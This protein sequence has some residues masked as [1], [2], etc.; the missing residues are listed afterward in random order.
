MVCCVAKT[1]S[2]NGLEEMNSVC[3]TH[4]GGLTVTSLIN[5][6]MRH[7]REGWNMMVVEG[8]WVPRNLDKRFG[9]WARSEKDVLF[10]VGMTHDRDGNPTNIISNFAEC[11][12][13]GILLTKRFFGEVGNFSDNPL[14]ISKKFWGLE[15]EDKGGVFK[16]ILGIKIC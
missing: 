12:L 14:E 3:R 2:K 13:N 6:G 9:M 8:S 7:A 4:R 15:A 10:P 5:K 1:I 11:S 16:G